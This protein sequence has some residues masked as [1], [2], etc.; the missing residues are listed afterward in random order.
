MLKLADRQAGLGGSH[1]AAVSLDA[2]LLNQL[3]GRNMWFETTS[4]ILTAGSGRGN[5]PLTAF[6]AAL[7]SAGIADFNLIKVTSIVPRG[8]P[9]L[10]L[11]R[12]SEPIRG[13]GLMA[14]AI[15]EAISSDREGTEL[16]SAIGVG[17]PPEHARDEGVVF[18]YS[19]LGSGEEA[20]QVVR[21]MVQESLRGKGWS[22]F[23]CFTASDAA[24]VV[25]PYTSVIA[26]ALFC[27]HDIE[28]LLDL[29]SEK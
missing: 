3:K 29:H 9:V 11:P 8:V 2:A 4:V 14:P 25:P 17:L 1:T 5:T 6:D 7:R 13:R 16:A 10:L 28:A 21:M 27:D 20:E 18:V 12:G 24:L 15:Y 26:A 19:C 23:E 22:A